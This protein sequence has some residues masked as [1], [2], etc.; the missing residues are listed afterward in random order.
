MPWTHH[1]LRRQ[2]SAYVDGEL[3][4]PASAVVERHIAQCWGCSSTVEQFGLIKVSLLHLSRDRPEAVGAA[5]L[6]P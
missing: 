4:L 6:R 3:E 5:H 1:R 2:V